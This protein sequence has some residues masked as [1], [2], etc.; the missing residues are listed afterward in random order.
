MDR[1]WHSRYELTIDDQPIGV[2]RGR[3]YRLGGDLELQG[4]CYQV[5]S[6]SWFS[7]W[8]F[9]LDAHGTRLATASRGKGRRQIIEAQGQTYH[10][11]PNLLG[12]AHQVH[13]GSVWVGWVE[14]ASFWRRDLG[15]AELPGLPLTVQAFILAVVIDSW[16][17]GVGGGGEAGGGE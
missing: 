10:L 6:P 16:T 7:D 12:T 4:H 3:F 1:T 13:V 2:W 17:K 15:A 9:M 14:R 11:S 5:R 8:C